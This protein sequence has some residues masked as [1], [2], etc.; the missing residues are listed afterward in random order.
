MVKAGD[1]WARDE[2]RVETE[3]LFS[4][5]RTKQDSC[6]RLFVCLPLLVKKGQR[7]SYG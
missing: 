7:I 4:D 6:F 2:E 5:T 1:L 3:R